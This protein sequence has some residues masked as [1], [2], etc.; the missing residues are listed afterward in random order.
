[1]TA[2][3]IFMA[4]GVDVTVVGFGFG[5]AQAVVWAL[6][7]AAVFDLALRLSRVADGGKEALW[8]AA[9]GAQVLYVPA[10]VACLLLLGAAILAIARG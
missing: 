9:D 7:S 4:I 3:L 1:M 6:G 2:V 5:K 10:W 8:S